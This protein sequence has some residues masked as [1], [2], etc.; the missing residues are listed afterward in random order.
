[1]L[2]CTVEDLNACLRDETGMAGALP[3]EL[4]AGMRVLSLDERRLVFTAK[5]RSASRRPTG[6]VSGP[7]L[8]AIIDT[9]GWLV[10][11]AHNWPLLEGV[12]TD[13]SMQFLRPARQGELV[14]EA[15]ALRIGRRCVI[16]VNVDTAG[17][18]GPAA[19]AVVTFAPVRR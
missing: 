19:H 1:M 16:D 17:D 4:A 15:T 10:T 7:V 3:A 2:Q 12:T 14:V 11:I 5:A 9:A 8:F 6:I 18:A 13:L